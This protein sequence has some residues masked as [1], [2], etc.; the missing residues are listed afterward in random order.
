MPTKN[1]KSC[2]DISQKQIKKPND[3]ISRIHLSTTLNSCGRFIVVP[4]TLPGE[5]HSSYCL[6][7]TVCVQ[8]KRLQHDHHLFLL[9][10]MLADSHLKQQVAQQQQQVVYFSSRSNSHVASRPWRSDRSTCCL[11]TRACVRNQFQIMVL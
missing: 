6:T 9:V 8:A 2:H 10:E 11:F 5:R 3:G 7:N 4:Q 1:N